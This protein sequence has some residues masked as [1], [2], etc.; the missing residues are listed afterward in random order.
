MI[1]SGH[2]QCSVYAKQS[3]VPSCELCDLTEL[4]S[5]SDFIF[6]CTNYDDLGEF[7][8]HE[9]TQQNLTILLYSPALVYVLMF[10]LQVL[11]HNVCDFLF[12]LLCNQVDRCNHGTIQNKALALMGFPWLNK[13]WIKWIKKRFVSTICAY[14]SREFRKLISH[15]IVLLFTMLLTPCSPQ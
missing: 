2:C 3:S 13:V 10:I 14:L 1:L 6:Y 4:E 8:F 7:I 15:V 9:M 11:S 5:D 12:I